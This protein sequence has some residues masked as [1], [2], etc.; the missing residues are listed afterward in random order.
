MSLFTSDRE[1]RLWTWTVVVLVAIYSTLGPARILVDFL[2]EQNLLRISFALVVLLVVG[3]IAWQWLKKRPGWP[4]IGVALGVAFAYLWMFLRIGSPEERTH[5][6]EYGVVA[7]VIHQAL[8]ERVRN[9][10]RVPAPAALTVAVTALLGTLDECI[11]AMLPNRVFDVRDIGFNALAGF[12]VIAARLALAPQKGPGW[13]FW[14]L[15]LMA[16]AFGWG[17]G[18]YWGWFA[19]GDPIILKSLP[20]VILGGY[21][22]VAVGGILVG[23]LQWLV[24]RRFIARAGRWVLTSLGAAAVV[25]VVIFGVGLLNEE[26]GWL[27][28]VGVFGTVVG[29]LQWA[30]LRRE[31]PWA[32]WWIVVSTVGWVVG[33][34][35][36]DTLGPPGLGGAYGVLTATT[37]VW[38][39]REK[40]KSSGRSSRR[41]W[42]APPP[43]QNQQ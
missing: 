29:V 32:G 40:S 39:L 12:M 41:Q 37:L 2:R 17:M 6:I 11:Q 27:V 3:A 1:R 15:W 30:V 10:R 25:G 34:P 33:L 20:T 8:Q 43:R 28:G 38:L 31:V 14:F 16:S 26:V 5:L 18:L 35:L 21:L 42:K 22:G 23:V 7:A 19:D 36:G 13:R 9:G 4:E 24:L